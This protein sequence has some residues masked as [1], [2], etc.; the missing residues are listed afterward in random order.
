MAQNPSSLADSVASL[1]FLSS[2]PRLLG[3]FLMTSWLRKSTLKPDLQA[4]LQST[5]GTVQSL[6]YRIT[7]LP[8]AFRVTFEYVGVEG[9]LSLGLWQ[10]Q[11]TSMS[12]SSETCRF[13]V[14]S[15]GWRAP[16]GFAIRAH[17]PEFTQKEGQKGRLVYLSGRIAYSL[18]TPEITAGIMGRRMDT[19]S[20][21]QRS[22]SLQVY[23][24]RHYFTGPHH[25]PTAIPVISWWRDGLRHWYR[26]ASFFPN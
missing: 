20:L 5:L 13:S 11:R 25:C 4:D 2:I 15:W 3:E 17:E 23:R 19:S 1:R 8:L 14:C 9:L 7:V 21:T 16:T 10:H 6:S 24:W 12:S 18:E 26:G 22:L